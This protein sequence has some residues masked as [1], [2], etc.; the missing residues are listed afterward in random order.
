MNNKLLAYLPP[1]LA[2]MLTSAV[3]LP[4]LAA[5]LDPAR[6]EVH[7]LNKQN[8]KPVADASV[9]LGTSAR[10]DQ[11]GARRSD[12]KGVVSFDEISSHPL[13]LT[14]SGNG[15]QGLRQA[16]EPLYESRV[17][18]VKLATGGGGPACDA[19]EQE[20][21]NGSL[22]GLSVDAV[23][24][25][26]DAGNAGVLVATRLSGT[27]NEI[28]ISEQVDFGDVAWRPYQKAV[29]F[30][31]SAGHGAKQLYVQVRRV[32]QVQGAS[33]EVVSPVKKVTYRGN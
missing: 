13:V 27:A 9:C 24:I 4:A 6:L 25:S 7:L 17:L 31:F 18:V 8:G 12:A 23:R 11:F 3:T 1:F 2:A 15:Y 28:R 22:S 19:P 30:T 14:V 26:E 33:I 21:G 16:L 5:T 10:T 32:A 20:A 29:P